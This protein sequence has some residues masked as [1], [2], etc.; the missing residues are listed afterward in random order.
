MPILSETLFGNN[1]VF[2]KLLYSKT[3]IEKASNDITAPF[4]T[5]LEDKC[6]LQIQNYMY[7]LI[8]TCTN[9]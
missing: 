1:L 4:K 2:S 8:Q 6:L 9:S 3:K 5:L 7:L